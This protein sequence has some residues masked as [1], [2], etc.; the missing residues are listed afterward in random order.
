MTN[1]SGEKL[2]APAAISCLKEK[3]ALITGFTGEMFA[4]LSSIESHSNF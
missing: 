1:K 4:P 2:V 3:L